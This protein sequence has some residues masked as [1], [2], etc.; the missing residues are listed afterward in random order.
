VRQPFCCLVTLDK[1]WKLDK[2]GNRQQGVGNREPRQAK[3]NREQ[4]TETWRQA[5]GS[6]EQGIGKA[7]DGPFVFDFGYFRGL[8][9]EAT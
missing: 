8:I 4:G 2:T 7:G 1:W 5:G 3:E 6:K 9:R